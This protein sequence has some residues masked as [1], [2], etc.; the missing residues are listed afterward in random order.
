MVVEA[1]AGMARVL[2]CTGRCCAVTPVGEPGVRWG[3]SKSDWCMSKVVVPV[4]VVVPVGHTGVGCVWLH[5]GV[6]CVWL[7]TGVGCV[8]LH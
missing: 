6:E 5:T 2:D 8:W 1:E 7:H 4:W 3:T